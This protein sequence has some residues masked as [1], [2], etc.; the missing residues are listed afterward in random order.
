[1]SWKSH[2]D[3]RAAMNWV[4]EVA[5]VDGPHCYADNSDNLRGKEL[6]LSN[7]Y[8][9]HVTDSQIRMQ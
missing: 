8:F 1:M 9:E 5:Y 3:P 6:D 2:L 4:A 7:E